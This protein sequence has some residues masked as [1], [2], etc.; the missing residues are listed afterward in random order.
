M[1]GASLPW[2]HIPS[3]SQPESTFAPIRHD[4]LG[5]DAPP[6][7][8]HQTWKSADTLTPDMKRSISEWKR[9]HPHW[10]HVF[11]DDEACDSF[12]RAH[13]RAYY[14]TYV[15]LPHGVMRAD[16]FRLAVLYTRGGMYADTDI[17]PNMTIDQSPLWDQG[18]LVFASW[19]HRQANAFILSK[20]CEDPRL[21]EVMDTI[22]RRHARNRQLALYDIA[23]T[24]RN[25]LII[26]T[27]GPG[28]VKDA[29]GRQSDVHYIPKLQYMPCD[30]CTAETEQCP[31]NSGMYFTHLKGR[32]WNSGTDASFISLKCFARRHAVVIA[33]LVLAF[34]AL[35]SG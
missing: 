17:V 11:W 9:L 20:R 35:R 28:V 29:I 26:F 34:V 8:I 24:L 32:S 13:H 18:S 27:T 6:M 12:M 1:D 14:N 31:I 33:L 30:V 3:R 22:V 2:A 25:P 19:E 23:A 15:D 16:M 4:A 21:L 10:T 5:L 7:E